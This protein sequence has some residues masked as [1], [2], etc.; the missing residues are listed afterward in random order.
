MATNPCIDIE[1]EFRKALRNFGGDEL[2][3]Q[4]DK[5][6]VKIKVA[7]TD[8]VLNGVELSARQTKL[9]TLAW[10]RLEKYYDQFEGTDKAKAFNDMMSGGGIRQRGL[11]S[12]ERRIDT[13]MGQAHAEMTEM[14]ERYRPRKLGFAHSKTAQKNWIRE[15]FKPGSTGDRDAAE[16]ARIW[17]EVVEK[18][19]TRA[20]RAGAGIQKLF[21]WNLPQYH[22]SVK[23]SRSSF[24]EWFEFTRNRIDRRRVA[25]YAVEQGEIVGA[26]LSDKD[27]ERLMKSVYNNLKSEGI[28]HLDAKAYNPHARRAI[29]NRHQQHRI[30]SFKDAESWMEYADEYGAADY[31]NSAMGHIELLSREIGAMETFGPNP[32]LMVKKLR[33]MIQ[34]TTGDRRTGQLAQDTYDVVMGRQFSNYTQFSDTMRGLR[35][36]STGMKIHSAI[37]SA[38]SDLAFTGVTAKFNDM[39]IAKTYMRFLKNLATGS[40]EDRMLAARLG[41][42]AEYAIDNAK[43]AHRLAEV[44]GVGGTARFADVVVR[45]SGLNYWTH[46]AKQVFGLEFLANMSKYVDIPFDKISPRLR[47]SFERYGITADDWVKIGASPRLRKQGVDFID[48]IK[49]NDDELTA[50]VIGMIREETNFAVPEPN[51]KTRAILTA[52]TPSGTIAGEMIRLATQFKSFAA[53]VLVSHLMRGLNL[54]GPSR[55]GYFAALIG[56]TTLLGGVALQAKNI[57]AGKTPEETDKNFWLAAMIQGGSLGIFGDFL[58]LDHTRFGSIS[59]LMAGPVAGDME[60]LARVFLGT[61]QEMLK[62]EKNIAAK[63][64]TAA[65]KTLRTYTP[66]LWYTKLATH[67]YINDWIDQQLDP[68][69]HSKQRAIRRRMAKERGQ[70]WFWR[71]GDPTPFE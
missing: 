55:L 34:Q 22:D 14:M 68:N 11:V 56:G 48:P 71:P 18:L 66:T 16:Y 42:L 6:N 29:G 50:K 7:I 58:F 9:R 69:W 3:E 33:L 12:L 8:D 35:N 5:A 30:L 47:R 65:A 64:G 23:L 45:A 40:K 38:L 37:I 15:I 67:R 51:A 60:S 25:A 32:D 10:N 24:E 28:I 27:F 21:D 17:H 59:E 31:Y 49:F 26:E 53:S 63:F 36:L 41:L 1:T 13:I 43:T 52:G 54:S 2:V 39:P 57:V 19:R 46:T 20:N 61:G 70:D 4:F 44:T 62:E